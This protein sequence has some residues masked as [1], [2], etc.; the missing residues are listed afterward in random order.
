MNDTAPDMKKKFAA[1]IAAR[2]PEE[3]LQ[4][5]SHM[6][7]TGRALLRVGLQKQYHTLDEAQLST[8][9]FLRL[10]KNDFSRVEINRI[11]AHISRAD[12]F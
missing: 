6:F 11:V 7:E 8:K 5:A 12:L 9:I 1:M 2:S 3:R 4:M 10:Y